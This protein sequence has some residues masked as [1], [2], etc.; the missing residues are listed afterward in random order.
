MKSSID[1]TITSNFQS[2]VDSVGQ[3]TADAVT[4]VAL[5]EKMSSSNLFGTNLPATGETINHTIN[6]GNVN[7]YDSEYTDIPG[8]QAG[9]DNTYSTS[10][11]QPSNVFPG[12]SGGDDIL[13]FAIPHTETGGY[14]NATVD[15]FMMTTKPMKLENDTLSFRS[16]FW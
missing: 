3:E 12:F 8:N 16:Y 5:A 11:N 9:I 13:Y 7:S 15:Y 14:S 6:I 4:K 10:H 2:W 1:G